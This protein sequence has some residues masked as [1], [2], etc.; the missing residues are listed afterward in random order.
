MTRNKMEYSQ[1]WGIPGPGEIFKEYT[2]KSEEALLPELD[3]NASGMADECHKYRL[4]ELDPDASGMAEDCRKR[5]APR[6]VNYLYINDMHGAVKAEMIVE[7]WGGHIGTTNQAFR[8]NG[9]SWTPIPQPRNTP[10]EPECYY[11]TVLGTPAVPIPLYQLKEGRNEIQF[12][13]GPQIARHNFNFGFFWI[14]SFTIRVYYSISKQL[15]STGVICSH[16]NGSLI[17]DL[18]EFVVRVQDRQDQIK[19]VDFMANYEDFDWKGIGEYRQWHHQ[20]Q[21]GEIKHHIGTAFDDPYKVI[22]DTTL[23]PD[24]KESVKVIARIC[25]IND[26]NYMTPAIDITLVRS[27]RTVKMYKAYDVPE[28]FGVRKG[29][30][31]KTCKID[32]GDNLSGAKAAY[33]VASTWCAAHADEFGINEICISK[34]LGRVH[35][36]SFE[37]IPVPLEVIKT[38]T[39]I[40]YI[41]STHEHHACEI[42]WPG[43]VLI[44]EYQSKS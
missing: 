42:N 36:Y 41:Y 14:Y 25:D 44:M 15:H 35:D 21:Y 28:A 31:K 2:F 22:W 39:N 3:T 19:K 12:S 11:R 9:N 13:A 32:I 8:V 17:A 30:E 4:P 18:P 26:M 1:Y 5:R 27:I 6:T 34:K 43:P 16:N 23:V 33:L 24:Q 7:Y 37:I 38:G 40:F 29:Y 20:Y 10:T